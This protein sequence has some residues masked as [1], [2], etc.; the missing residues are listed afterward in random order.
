METIKDEIG[1]AAQRLGLLESEI[2]LLPEEAG[3]RVFDAA[4]EHFVVGGDRVWWWEAFR[5]P[6]TW[7][8]FDDGRAFER[9]VAVAP[10]PDER[11]WFVAEESHLPFYPVY[12]TTPR[13]AESVIGACYGFEYYLIAKD[14]SWLICETHHNDLVA[15]G[16]PA[17]ERLRQ[18]ST[19][20][21]HATRG[22]PPGG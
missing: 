4:V 21:W 14:F 3:R 19:E 5:L 12:E 1:T 2:R 7:R 22:A 6:A 20:P 15:I 9:I 11:V 13:T 8:K 18:L 10:D 16:E 17:E